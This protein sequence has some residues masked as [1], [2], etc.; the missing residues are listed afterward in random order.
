MGVGVVDEAIARIGRRGHGRLLWGFGR[1]EPRAATRARAFGGPA[2]L[3]PA[4]AL[5]L[6][7]GV[8]GPGGAARAWP[9]DPEGRRAAGEA[10]DRFEADLDGAASATAV[11]GAW[12]AEHALADPPVIQALPAD[13]P[14][15]PASAEIRRRLRAGP[16]EAVRHRGVR[17]TCGDHV[18]SQADNWYRPGQ[19]TPEMN[20]RLETTTTPFGV[21]VKP[22]SFRRETLKVE[23]L[24]D[25]SA[26]PAEP[27]PGGS[28]V[29]PRQLL[30]H[31]AVLLTGEGAPFSLV[32]ETYTADILAFPPASRPAPRR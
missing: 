2:R 13:G 22:L 23:R 24:F 3:V 26:A 18:L 1:S 29:L 9:G 32:V 17:L 10:L 25:P 20:R 7:I 31:R 11:L 30:R 5:A 27:G 6:A 19:L 21:V 12:C 15:K 14:D 16:G 8:P 28:L 4:L